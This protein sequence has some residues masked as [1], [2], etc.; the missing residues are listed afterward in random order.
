MFAY[1]Y[2][3]RTLSLNDARIMVWNFGISCS[4]RPSPIPNEALL[5]KVFCHHVFFQ[6]TIF[7]F[8][9]A[10]QKLN[11]NYFKTIDILENYFKEEDI[12]VMEKLNRG[13]INWNNKP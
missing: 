4:Q 2:L 8:F 9:G 12:C 13:R 10:K 5:A 7:Q 1:C 3:G 11:E 6:K